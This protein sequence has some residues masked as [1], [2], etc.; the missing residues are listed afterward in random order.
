[1][2]FM[3]RSSITALTMTML[4]SAPLSAQ[5]RDTVVRTATAPVHVGVAE[6]R[7]DLA[8]GIADGEQSYM[9]GA[10]DDIA[11]ATNGTMYV[12]DRSVPT[13]RVYD[14][15]GRVVRNIGQR[16]SGP[17]E[18]RYATA[19]ALATNGNLLL[20]DQGNARVNVYTPAGDVV[21]SWM[22]KAG[23]GSGSGKN[24]LVSDATGTTYIRSPIWRRGQAAAPR[25]AW[26]RY[27][28][29]GTLRDTTYGPDG[30]S[31]PL[32]LAQRANASKSAGIPFAP[33]YYTAV[34]PLGYFVTTWSSALAIETHEPGKPVVSIR[35]EIPLQPVTSR[36]RD[37]ARAEVT[38][39]MRQMDPAW[40]WNG[41]GIP[42]TKAAHFGLRVGDD[43]VVWVQLAHGPKLDDGSGRG[44]GQ[45]SARMGAGNNP[46]GVSR[47]ATWPCPS[48]PWTLHDLFEPSGRYLG[49]VK[50]PE[51]VDVILTRGDYVWAATCNEDDAP[52]VVR[53]KISW[54]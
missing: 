2:R 30:P 1:M 25:W 26:F 14:A 7:R 47:A 6:L 38:E 13:V 3:N 8:I 17:G 33:S 42:R 51:K 9:L 15:T 5:R 45:P 46:T 52:Q 41:P 10:I 19:I 43:G 48:N 16:G 29:D 54:K 18:Y 40:S 37:S 4:A 35:R 39:S 32:L 53:Y 24:I 23:S 12:L 21:T 49:Q 20:Y 11:V 50:L 36:E 44:G 28:A 27:A 34:S 22:T 31:Q